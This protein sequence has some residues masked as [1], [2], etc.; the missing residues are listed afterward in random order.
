MFEGSGGWRGVGET[1]DLVEWNSGGSVME[2]E[3]SEEGGRYGGGQC[4]DPGSGH[5]REHIWADGR[6]RNKKRRG[7]GM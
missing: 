4:E 5:Q 3:R 6:E 7:S 1:G 2:A